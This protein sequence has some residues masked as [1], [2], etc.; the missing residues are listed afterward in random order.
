MAIILELL[1]RGHAG[2]IDN[3]DCSQTALHQR[4]N[5]ANSEQSLSSVCAIIKWF[6]N[7]MKRLTIVGGVY[8]R[9]LLA[10]LFISVAFGEVDGIGISE[11]NTLCETLNCVMLENQ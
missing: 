2:A 6:E 8:L 4:H 11:T 10:L 3:M 1:V 7:I 5:G 9:S